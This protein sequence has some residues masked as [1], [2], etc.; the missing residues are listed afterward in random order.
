MV[1]EATDNGTPP[2]VRYQRVVCNIQD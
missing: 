2:R 1:L